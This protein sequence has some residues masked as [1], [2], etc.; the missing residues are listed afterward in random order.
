MA[1]SL[2]IADPTTPNPT[3]TLTNAFATG[4]GVRGV[5]SA[6]TA[7]KITA[8]AEDK[9]PADLQEWFFTYGRNDRG[10]RGHTNHTKPHNNQSGSGRG[11]VGWRRMNNKQQS[12]GIEGE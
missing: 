12:A 6:A 3:N 4:G 10:W 2:Q 8:K 1:G 11:N 9:C 7:V 5:D